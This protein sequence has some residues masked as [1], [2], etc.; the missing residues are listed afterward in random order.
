MKYIVYVMLLVMFFGLVV[1]NVVVVDYKFNFFIL[2]Y[3]GVIMWNVF[4]GVNVYL[5]FY[6]LNGIEIVVNFYMLVNFD[7]VWKYLIIVVV[8]FNGGVKEQVV[9][10]YVQCLVE[11]GYI[12][13][14]VDVVY[15]G[16]SGGQLCSVDMFF[17]CIED[18]YGM[19]DFIS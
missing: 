17:Y 19:V 13:I 15:Q 2:V 10:L 1:G 5:V 6:L 16:V 12:V 7:V 11:Q 3:E 4:S 8:Y 18:I 9:G 14:I